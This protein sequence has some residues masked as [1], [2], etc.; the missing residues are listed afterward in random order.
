MNWNSNLFW[1]IIGALFSLFISSLFYFIGIKR[2]CLT[3]SIKTFCL[4]SNKINQINGL[5]VKYN[6]NVIDDLYSSTITIKNIGNSVIEKQDF[7][8]SCPISIS[9]NGQF[10]VDESNTTN[11]F[12]SNKANNVN[13]SFNTSENNITNNIII[14]FD[15]LS[16]KE[17]LTCSIFHTGKISFD[18]GVLK[19]G[20]ILTPAQYKK[21]KKILKYLLESIVYVIFILIEYIILH[22]FY[23]STIK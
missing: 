2:K 8:P 5:E 16:K 19:D 11:L 4:V 1:C 22:M 15:Y 23:I 10:L 21:R 18:D 17:E 20:K 12:S 13:I 3:Y 14:C 7:A 6:S 9:T